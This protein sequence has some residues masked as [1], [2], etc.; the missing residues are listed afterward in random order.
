[1]QQPSPAASAQ[2]DKKDKQT[3]TERGTPCVLPRGPLSVCTLNLNLPSYHS[4]QLWAGRSSI[5]LF[6]LLSLS[7]SLLSLSLL[8]LCQ[9][10][11]HLKPTTS[12]GTLPRSG[13][14]RARFRKP[15]AAR[16]GNGRESP[17]GF[18]GFDF[19]SCLQDV[20]TCGVQIQRCG[21]EGEPRCSWGSVAWQHQHC[22][23]HRLPPMHTWSGARLQSSH[24][25]GLSQASSAT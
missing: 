15:R 7:L 14:I 4:A 20:R 10:G 22:P 19:T 2:K 23:P 17:C 3:E 8:P 1:L 9:H 6:S 21:G 25:G 13:G 16:W 24:P 12:S 18:P 11:V 5:S